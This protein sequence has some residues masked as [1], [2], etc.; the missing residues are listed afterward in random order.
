VQKK[1]KEA[2]LNTQRGFF[3]LG[4]LGARTTKA[5]QLIAGSRRR[6]RRLPTR[7]IAVDAEGELAEE[8]LAAAD[9]IKPDGAEFGDRVSPVEN[10]LNVLLARG[11][12][13]VDLDE[14]VAL[15]DALR[16]GG[17]S[18]FHGHDPHASVER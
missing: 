6:R 16:G 13:A 9:D 12:P 5:Q 14:D 11:V 17:T 10:E 15:H 3:R 18:R 7:R 4:C 1:E 2:S 8:P